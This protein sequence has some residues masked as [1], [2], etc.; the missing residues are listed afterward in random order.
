MDRVE[1]DEEQIVPIDAIAPGLSGL[2]LSATLRA[3]N[4]KRLTRSGNVVILRLYR[5]F[6]VIRMF[7]IVCLA[8]PFLSLDSHTR[9]AVRKRTTAYVSVSPLCSAS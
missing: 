6:G 4:S 5:L 2:T 9:G 8:D 1:I 3:M 7:L